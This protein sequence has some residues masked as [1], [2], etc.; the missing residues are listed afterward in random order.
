VNG[1]VK[2]DTWKISQK[3][4][5]EQY[6]E[7]IASP[8]RSSLNP[9]VEGIAHSGLKLM[10]V[11]YRKLI[12]VGRKTEFLLGRKCSQMK[13]KFAD[14]HTRGSGK[15]LNDHFLCVPQLALSK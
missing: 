5:Q 12:T 13:I 7:N 11:R 9:A 6:A 14:R 10:T 15:S 8:E 4:L 1:S 2:W 3:V